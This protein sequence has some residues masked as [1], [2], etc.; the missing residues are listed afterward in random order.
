MTPQRAGADPVAVITGLP[1]WAAVSRAL[2]T[3]LTSLVLGFTLAVGPAQ[4]ATFVVDSTGDA[5]AV[6]STADGTCDADPTPA[7]VCTLRAAIQEANGSGGADLIDFNIAP[8]GA[9]TIVL[10]GAL[11]TIT[12]VVSINGT[13]QP[14]FVASPPYAPVIEINGAAGG[15]AVLDLRGGS[16]GS[17][18]RGL[19]INRCPLI[20][21]RIAGS[22]NNVIAG[23]FLGTNL[24]GTAAGPGNQ[25]GVSIGLSAVATNGNRVG[26]TAAADRNV[27][28]GNTTDGIQINAGSGG[29]ANNVVEGNYIGVD[30]NGTLPVPN[31]NQGVAL[32]VTSPNTN[33]NNL[34]GGT[35]AGAGNVISGNGNDGVLIANVGTTGTR[36]EGN[37]IGTNAAGTAAIPNLRGVEI[38]ASATGSTIGG[39]AA[40]AGNVI[41]GNANLGILINGASGNTVQRNRIGTDMAGSIKVANGQHGIQLGGGASSNLIGGAAGVGNVISGNTLN[42]V[43][44]IGA[45]ASGNR[46]AGNVIGLDAAGTIDLGN[47]L[48]GV[49]IAQGASGNIIGEAGGGNVISG[50]DMAGVRILDVGTDNN[51]VQLNYIGLDVTGTLSRPNSFEGV[52]LDAGGAASG[53]RIGGVGL[54]N[55]ISG[56]DGAG[57]RIRNGMIGTLVVANIIGRD[58]TNSFSIGNGGSGVRIE[59]SSG[60]SVGGTGAGAGNIVAGNSGD[61]V[62]VLGAATGNTI[63]RNASFSNTGLGIDLGGD[64]V[65]PNDLGDVDAGPNGLLNFP[66]ITS[67]AEAVGVLTVDFTLDVPVGSYRIEF[68]KNP[69][70]SDPSGYGEGETF[71]SSRNVDHPGGGPWPFSHA[72][73]GSVG[74]V[75]T[76]TT[77]FCTDGATCAVFGSTSEFGNFFTALPQADLA[78]IKTDD[79][80]PIDIGNLLTYTLTVTNNGPSNATGV[81]VTDTLVPEMEFQSATPSQGLCNYDVPTRTLTCTLGAVA[82]AG[83]ATVDLIVRP[84]A[85]GT[86]SNSASVGGNEPDL[87]SGN[88]SAT[89]TTTVQTASEGV[90]FFTVTST[91]ETNVLEW[92]NPS[93]D[94]VSTEIVYR[95]DR[96]PTAPGEPGSTTISNSGTAGMK[97]RFVHGTGAG[98]NNLTHYYGA[99]VHR[100]AAPL[101]SAGRFCSGRPFNNAGPVRWAFSTG[102][103]SITPPT[104]GGAGVVA[105]A[106]DRA[107]YAMERGPLGGEWPAGWEPAQLGGV[108]QSRSPVVPI[109]VSGANPV[110]YLG[111]QDGS[112]YVVDGAAGGAAAFPWAPRSIAGMVQAAPAGI[113]SAFGAAQNYLL[114]GT[115]DDGADNKLVALNPDTPGNVIATFDNGGGSSGIGVINAMAAV[116]Y[117][118][119]RVYFASH[120]HPSGSNG[121][122]WC[123]QL[124]PPGPTFSL[125][126]QRALQDIDGSPVPRGDR[127]YVGSTDGGGTVY[128]IDAA[129]G[130]ILLDRTFV[131]GDG[132]VKGFVWPDRSSADLYFATNNFVWAIS[133]TGAASMPNKFASGISLGGSVTPST[134]LFVPGS[135]YVYTGGS[136]GSL[137]EIDVL[138]AIPTLKSQPLGDGLATVGA[139][140]LDWFYSL[141][142]VGTEAGIFYAVD[143]PL[144]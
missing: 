45:G 112:V 74:D 141:V 39:A 87:A 12:S 114:V 83:G 66:Q 101:V 60:N 130:N 32:F 35:A 30:V 142:H 6:G 106:N 14:G 118:T 78:L 71:A 21:I 144:P 15:A 2:G 91:F 27:I 79:I 135:H 1:G 62:A 111:A 69:S 97:D 28:S 123:L 109:L 49:A 75:I 84:L 110:V 96:F 88:N 131:H 104:V 52:I 25:V 113:F 58:P 13:T 9:K 16:S 137:Y 107:L 94:Y 117:S 42:G 95:T 20:A 34:I 108:V 40:G 22:S 92:L 18:I 57:V 55:V 140:S 116:D 7:I 33:T 29:A 132:P 120:E 19:V 93:V 125:V 23:N 65:T 48:F 73:A 85:L 115:R 64:S 11:P 138:G 129:T 56:N 100:T 37:R 67:V 50:N 76:A 70:G 68:F 31:T 5:A 82:S 90:R 121:T 51:L 143:S 61:G 99:F 81:I 26:G 43:D 53:N 102:A 86:L 44:I 63:V 36:V 133:D 41:S 105:P 80:D 59:G 4:A 136:D 134:V 24:A 89:Q 3:G 77:T 47:S 139:P 103:F 127:V 98:S 72:F 54:G 38:I 8:A 119:S 126:W 124:G 128:S 10:G 17:T 46:V 122:L